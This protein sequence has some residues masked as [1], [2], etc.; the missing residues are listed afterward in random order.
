MSEPHA[1]NRIELTIHLERDASQSTPRV[2]AD[3]FQAGR[4]LGV[5][6]MTGQIPQV[7]DELASSLRDGDLD[8]LRTRLAGPLQPA[9]G[10]HLFGLLFPERAR[11][12]EVLAALRLDH[13]EGLLRHAFRVRIHTEDDRWASLPWSLTALQHVRLADADTGWT[14]EVARD[15]TPA[16]RPA[17]Y[18]RP[19]RIV[20]FVTEAPDLDLGRH[21]DRLRGVLSA[22]NRLYDEDEVFTVVHRLEALRAICRGGRVDIVYLLAHVQGGG[23]PRITSPGEA[24][25]SFTD[26]RLDLDRAEARVVFV[27]G[28]FAGGAFE[29]NAGHQMTHRIDTVIA[30]CTVMPVRAATA[31]AERW[32][33]EHVIAGRSPVDALF[34]AR[35]DETVD[36][37]A[38]AL[39]IAFT[40]HGE[41]RARPVGSLRPDV[42]VRLDRFSQRAHASRKVKELLFQVDPRRIQVLVGAG[43]PGN[44]IE[45]LTGHLCQDLAATEPDWQIVRRTLCLPDDRAMLVPAG[46]EWTPAEIA[47]GMARLRQALVDVLA[48]GEDIPLKDAIGFAFGRPFPGKVRLL[49]LDWGAYGDRTSLTHGERL[50]LRDDCPSDTLRLWFDFHRDLALELGPMSSVKVVAS[51]GLEK[52]AHVFEHLRDDVLEFAGQGFANLGVH[53]L[54]PLERVARHELLEFLRDDPS[55]MVPPEHIR[56]ITDT[57]MQATDGEYRPLVAAIARGERSRWREYIS[58]TPPMAR[59]PKY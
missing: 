56:E 32:F 47:R 43:A 59:R 24:P 1:R 13:R 54:P 37:F 25:V 26:L 5:V 39:P 8:A 31:L 22:H 3:Y 14:F 58:S 21:I 46:E 50:G 12:H 16:R 57:L 55:A 45:E 51:I 34:L 52:P 18:E 42:A 30:P 23:V 41:W 19:P 11:I 28:C 2:R 33:L 38:W 15:I 9:T 35:P 36:D 4:P 10:R 40:R 49:W 20:A 48:G 44:L 17:G 29:H 53:L 7:I 6:P 27:N